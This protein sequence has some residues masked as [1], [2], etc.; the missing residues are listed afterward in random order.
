[1]SYRSTAE[2]KNKTRLDKNKTGVY[3]IKILIQEI[4]AD[5][6]YQLRVF[7]YVKVK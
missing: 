4:K 1:M 2:I 5:H 3:L 7:K 6:G